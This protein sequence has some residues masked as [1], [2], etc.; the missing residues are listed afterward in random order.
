M[1]WRQL[2]PRIG[3]YHWA[4]PAPL[5]LPD[6]FSGCDETMSELSEIDRLSAGVRKLSRAKALAFGI[7]VL[8]RAMSAFIEFQWDTGWGG[9]AV[10]RAAIARC[11]AVL[12]GGPAEAAHTVSVAQCE[13]AM[14]DSEGRHAS[15][16]TSAAIDAVDIACNLLTFIENGDIELIVNAVIAQTDT[17][18]LFVRQSDRS[19]HSLLKEELDLMRA[20]LA[21][22][23]ALDIDETMLF[24]AVLKRVSVLDYRALRLKLPDA[25][26]SADSGATSR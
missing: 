20:D 13:R 23:S 2:A 11:W 6:D 19:T 7:C 24:P 1:L 5:V 4:V 21:F 10:M 8:E 18:D 15:D 26:G 17:I 9:G 16:Y 3:P 12:E 25:P 14:P 22:I